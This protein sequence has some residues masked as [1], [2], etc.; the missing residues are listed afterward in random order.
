MLLHRLPE[1]VMGL[2]ALT[3]GM[4]PVAGS[5]SF[6][7][8]SDVFPKPLRAIIKLGST[9]F[10]FPNHQEYDHATVGGIWYSTDLASWTEVTASRGYELWGKRFVVGSQIVLVA[11]YWTY[12]PEEYID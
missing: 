10:A 5:S 2:P 9:W 6:S 8:T 11:Y 7:T 4:Y 12:D 1:K 3:A